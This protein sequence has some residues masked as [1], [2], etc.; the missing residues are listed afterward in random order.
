MLRAS[1]TTVS[2]FVESPKL[3]GSGAMILL[4]VM[5]THSSD[6]PLKLGSSPLASLLETSRIDKPEGRAAGGGGRGCACVG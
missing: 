3:D 1:D 6:V 2:V 4:P 5:F